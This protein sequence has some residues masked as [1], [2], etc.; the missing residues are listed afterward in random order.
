M[1]LPIYLSVAKT[2]ALLDAKKVEIDKRNAGDWAHLLIVNPI[3]RPFVA[4]W[5][6]STH[7]FRFLNVARFRL[8]VVF[9]WTSRI[10][11]I[12]LGIGLVGF[13]LILLFGVFGAFDSPNPTAPSYSSQGV[14]PSSADVNT[15]TY[16]A[17]QP[18]VY[19]YNSTPSP[20]NNTG[21]TPRVAPEDVADWSKA[22]YDATLASKMVNVSGYR[23][24][25][26]YV[27]SYQRQ[28][29]GGFT[30]DDQAKAAGAAVVVAAVIYGVDYAD[31]KY[32]EWKSKREAES[33]RQIQEQIRIQAQASE[34]E[35]QREISRRV[36]GI[37]QQNKDQQKKSWFKW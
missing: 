6:W 32:T 13:L 18:Q 25:A 28:P 12:L 19:Q 11:A 34:Q 14:Q 20:S 33:Q 10:V 23:R 7:A 35:R 29:P 26:T 30:F 8:L 36:R 1:N 17:S 21:Y 4:V 5:Y 31:Q 27:E 9:A 24:G 22:A 16:N 3:F 15:P 37:N 2:T